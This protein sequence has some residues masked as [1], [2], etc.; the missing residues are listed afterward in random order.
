MANK[1]F[2]LGILGGALH[3]IAG[4]PHF[5]ASQMDGRFKVVS[6]VFSTNPKVN[7]DTAEYWKIERVYNSIDEFIEKEKGKLDAVSVL[8]PTPL[9]YEVVKKLLLNGFAVICEKPLFATLEEIERLPKEVNLEDKFLV[10]TYNYI[11]YPLLGVLRKKILQGDFG[12]ILNIHL[13]MPQE[14]FL[15]PP[16]GVKN[17]PPKWRKKDG[18]IPGILLDLMSHLFSLM[19]FLTEKSI[20]KVYSV[21]RNFSS[22][23]VVDEVKVI[24]EF[25]DQ[26]LGFFWV[27]KTA[28]GNRNG[29]KV[30]IYGTK[31]SALWVQEDP[32]KVYVSYADGKK[33]IWDRSNIEFPPQK[34]KLYNRMTPG[35]PAG[36]IEAFANLYWDIAKALEKFKAGESYKQISPLIW[37]YEREKENFKFLSA[38]V[39]SAK[40]NKEV[41]IDG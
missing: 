5:V 12:E 20:K 36:F 7:R 35:H 11:A 6:G 4:Y 32:E 37:T 24:A 18:P 3:S 39:K 27:S 19:K 17:Y 23:E 13:E 2:K 25:T 41:F 38:V 29:L 30:S 15:R 14:S 9:H 34:K 10:V 22:F 33:C 21:C 1:P 8:L 28:L 40:E 31:A 16:K 26:S